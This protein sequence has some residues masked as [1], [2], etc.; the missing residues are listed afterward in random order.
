MKTMLLAAGAAALVLA[1]FPAAAVEAAAGQQA[2]RPEPGRAQ[3][4]R[5]AAAEPRAGLDGLE[6]RFFRCENRRAFTAKEFDGKASVTTATGKTYEM[7][8]ASGG[9][10]EAQGVRY[11]RSGVLTGVPDETYENCVAS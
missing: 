5:R 4:S 3:S 8:P 1:G 10:F 7:E 9:G 11:E 6:I 2:S